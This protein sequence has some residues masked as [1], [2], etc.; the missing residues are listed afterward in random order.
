MR[1][2]M[3][4]FQSQEEYPEPTESMLCLGLWY[5]Y[6]SNSF[7][8]GW[9]N[10]VELKEGRLLTRYQER[11]EN[12]KAA[13]KFNEAKEYHTRLGE[14]LGDDVLILARSKTK[15]GIESHWWAFWFDRDSSDCCI[16]RFETTDSDE[17]VIA[18]FIK[19]A[20]E[21]SAE[22]SQTTSIKLEPK[23]FRGWICS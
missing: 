3:D 7:L 5:E 19:Y 8:D 9:I 21:C 11:D 6:I 4:Y 16:G 15:Q 13:E 23:A 20:D 2:F 17:D 14:Q 1:K 18:S 10:Y 12:L 22:H